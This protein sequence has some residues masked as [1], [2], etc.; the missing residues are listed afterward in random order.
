MKRYCPRCGKDAAWPKRKP[1]FCA[2]SCAAKIGLELLEETQRFC[3]LPG[4]GW[5]SICD[6]PCPECE[7][8]KARERANLTCR[9]NEAAT[10]QLR[11]ERCKCGSKLVLEHIRDLLDGQGAL[12][13]VSVMAACQDDPL[14]HKRAF[15]VRIEDLPPARLCAPAERPCGSCGKVFAVARTKKSGECPRCGAPWQKK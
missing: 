2:E 10:M 7:N 13:G 12:L 4:H 6:A 1:M 5:Y 3:N 11:E 15:H 14:R 9:L 8:D